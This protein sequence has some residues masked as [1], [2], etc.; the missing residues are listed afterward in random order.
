MRTFLITVALIFGLNLYAQAPEQDPKPS[1]PCLIV[2]GRLLQ[3]EESTWSLTI[4]E[5]MGGLRYDY[6]DSARMTSTKL[7]YKATE[8]RKLRANGTH[9]IAPIVNDQVDSSS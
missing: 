9:V 5:T 6:V 1:A 2:A 4:G 7:T 8:L 3:D